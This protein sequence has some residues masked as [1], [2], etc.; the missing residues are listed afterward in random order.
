MVFDHHGN[1]EDQPAFQ[2][3]KDAPVRWNE[4]RHVNFMRSRAQ[5]VPEWLRILYTAMVCVLV[6]V[7]V[8]EYG[9]SNFLWFSNIALLATLVAIWMGNRL[10][11]SMMALAVVLPE[12]GWNIGFWGRLFFGFDLFG[13]LNYMFD[14]RIPLLVRLLSLYHVPL[15]FLLV[16]LVWRFGYEPRAL[17]WQVVVAWVVLLIS[18]FLSTPEENINWVYGVLD[19]GGPVLPPPLQLIALMAALPLV[20]YWP[21]HLLLKRYFPEPHCWP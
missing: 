10:L 11:V 18:F 7:Y 14:E 5:C 19:N 9:F 4:T 6:P 21:T 17:K 16:W 8:M 15:P 3:I 20:V 1:Y 2:F 13:L 12:I